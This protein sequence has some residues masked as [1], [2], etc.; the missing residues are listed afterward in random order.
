MLGFCQRGTKGN[1]RKGEYIRIF[2]P[3]VRCI[4][5]SCSQNIFFFFFY[6]HQRLFVNWT[7]HLNILRF[8]KG[9]YQQQAIISALSQ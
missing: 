1:P 7:A 6:E 8:G 3:S 2:A 5:K 4:F 9:Q